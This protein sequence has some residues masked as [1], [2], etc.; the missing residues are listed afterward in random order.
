MTLKNLFFD[1]DGTILESSKGIINSFRHTFAEIDYPQLPESV[2]NTFIGPPLEATF[3]RLSNGDKAWADRAITTYRQYYAAKG[4][5]EAEPYDGILEMLDELQ[6]FDYQLYIATSK[7][8]DVAK[9]MLKALDLSQYFKG[10]F[11]N[12]PQAHSKTL[13]LRKSLLATQ[14]T[15]DTSAMIG[16]REYD[17][18]G[19]L[20]NKVAKTIGVLWGFGDETELKKAGSDIIIAKPQQLLE[21]IK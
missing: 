15:P 20:E 10:I 2:L 19:G 14:S 4:M 9:K 5:L 1:L 12:T 16:D 17:I 21:R 3:H 11:G 13:V 7:K 8:E 6:R 18:I